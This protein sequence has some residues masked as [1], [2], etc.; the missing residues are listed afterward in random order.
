VLLKKNETAGWACG[1]PLSNPE[2]FG[3]VWERERVFTFL[4]TNS[5]AEM[6]RQAQHRF[7]FLFI[8]E[9]KKDK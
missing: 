9:K 5:N 7:L 4:A 8:M 1:F 2:K 6:F 3:R